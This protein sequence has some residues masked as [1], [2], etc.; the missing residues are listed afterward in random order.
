MQQ[1]KLCSEYISIPM[2]EMVY[3]K[4]IQKITPTDIFVSGTI[5]PE[6]YLKKFRGASALLAPHVDPPMRSEICMSRSNKA[7]I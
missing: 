6:T 7:I 2:Q 5:D 4:A 3:L 1:N